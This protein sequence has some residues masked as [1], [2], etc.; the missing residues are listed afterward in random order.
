MKLLAR[1]AVAILVT[2]CSSHALADEFTFTNEDGDT[3]V[4][5][6]RLAGSGQKLHALELADGQ[7]LLVQQAAVKQ[8]KIADGPKP[9]DERQMADQLKKMFVEERLLIEIERPF[10]LAMILAG[11]K[12]SDPDLNR[13]QALIKKAG[14]FLKTVQTTFL[15]FIRQTRVEASPVQYPLVV[16]I[17]ESDRNFNQYAAM[18][19]NQKGLSAANIAGFYSQVSNHLVLRM[20]ECDSFTTPLHESIH[21]Q[22][23]NRG[24]FQRL[25]PVPTWVNE[26]MATGFEGDGSKVRNG[27]TT[28]STDYSKLALQARRVDWKEIVQADRA[29]RGDVF[30]GEAYGHA[31]GLHWLLVTKYRAQYGKYIRVMSQ[32]EPLHVDAA[33]VR[34]KDFEDA[35]GKNVGELQ[36]EFYTSVAR[37]LKRKRAGLNGLPEL[38]MPSPFQLTNRLL[39]LPPS[40]TDSAWSLAKPRMLPRDVRISGRSTS[41]DELRGLTIDMSRPIAERIRLNREHG[42]DF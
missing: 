31:W 39:D 42:V 13:K 36:A 34:L 25:S 30:A 3:V 15:K 17:F 40:P 4:A 41:T 11:P 2:W 26:G 6:A 21:M 20:S 18:V 22:V 12:E 38:L 32:K 1:G 8:R 28:V 5:Q 9:I 27:P 19:T 16:L 7:L 33:D 29:F 23:H 35:I 10:V 24:I 14:S 37:A